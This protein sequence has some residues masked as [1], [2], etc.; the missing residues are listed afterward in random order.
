MRE[1][2]FIDELTAYPREQL[3]EFVYVNVFNICRR[4]NGFDYVDFFWHRILGRRNLEKIVIETRKAHP[5]LIEHG[6]KYRWGILRFTF[7]GQAYT[8]TNA[9]REYLEKIEESLKRV[10]DIKDVKRDEGP[11]IKSPVRMHLKAKTSKTKFGISS[12]SESHISTAEY[13]L[14]NAIFS[15]FFK[16]DFEL[17]K[18]EENMR[19]YFIVRRFKYGE[20]S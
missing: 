13:H 1:K 10:E 3:R 19:E 5:E 14:L 20:T 18:L 4:I 8:L 12:D 7:E 2:K 9:G 17:N 16:K 11:A 6:S 15:G